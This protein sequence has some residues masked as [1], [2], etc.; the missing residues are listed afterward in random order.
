MSSFPHTTLTAKELSRFWSKILKTEGCW[1]WTA[2]TN[3]KGYGKFGFQAVQG[4]YLAHRVSWLI[5]FGDVPDG[6]DVLHTCDNPPCVRPDHF[7]L[8]TN[9]ENN[10]DRHEKGRDGW[11]PKPG[12][13]N[14]CAKLTWDQVREIRVASGFQRDIAA[15][16]GVTQTNISQIKRGLT[17]KEM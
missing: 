11:I 5:H 14:G 4:T 7:F 3:R 16:Y 10:R 13:E 8:G 17:W 15:R 9:I 6:M 2:G 1:L 12:E